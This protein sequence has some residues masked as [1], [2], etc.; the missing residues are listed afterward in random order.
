MKT[1]IK[2]VAKG[3]YIQELNGNIGIITGSDETHVF[4][5]DATGEEQEV[6]RAGAYKATRKEYGTAVEQFEETETAEIVE[7]LGL[8]Q[9]A[10]DEAG[11]EDEDGATKTIIKKSYLGTYAPVKS[12]SG[13]SSHICGDDVS[14]MLVGKTVEEVAEIV[15]EHTG[16]SGAAM[17]AQYA[18]LNPGQQRM[19][20]GNRFRTWV[21]A[22]A[23]AA[24]AQ[25]E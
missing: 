16:W 2:R 1:L 9:D 12:A 11:A 5:I 19:C 25:S 24:E 8:E 3:G 22:Q 13:H 17:L 14:M 21:K 6:A 7:S 23:A 18:H 10:E 4:Y 20:I 15:E